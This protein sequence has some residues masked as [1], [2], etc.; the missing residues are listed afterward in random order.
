MTA[1]PPAA[2]GMPTEE[3]IV[4][5][6]RDWQMRPGFD[7]WDAKVAALAADVLSLIRPAFEAKDAEI[8]WFKADRDNS[9]SLLDACRHERNVLQRICAE[10]ADVLDA[11][12]AKLAKAV[13]ALRPFAWPPLYVF[14][15]E[16]AFV[17]TKMPDDWEGGGYFT[18][19]DFRRARTASAE[20]RHR[21]LAGE[22]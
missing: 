9:N 20:S 13:E 17:P 11:A 18:T 2:P 19:E 16:M 7:G 6:V 4:R 1:S 14:D 15:K 3:E 8:A 22:A 10:R 5:V 12:E 21:P